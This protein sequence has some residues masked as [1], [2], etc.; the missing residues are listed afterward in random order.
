MPVAERETDE[1]RAEREEA[2]REEAARFEELVAEALEG[3]PPQ[4]AQYL[5]NIIVAVEP[6]PSRSVR[7]TL[8]LKQRETLLG[9]YHGVPQTERSTSYGAVMPDRVEIY[10]EPILDEADS[11]CPDDGDFEE[12]VREVVRT[13]VLHEIGHHF[14]MSDE[15]LGRVDYD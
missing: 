7:R 6:W 10:R 11:T 9:Y 12:T 2:E 13:T 5:E 14:G 3:L 1:E 15:D 8:G 4:F